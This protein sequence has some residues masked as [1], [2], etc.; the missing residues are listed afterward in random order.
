MIA[1]YVELILFVISANS[2]PL[3][4]FYTKVSVSKNALKELLN[5]TSYA[6]LVLRNV[7]HVKIMIH[8]LHANHKHLLMDNA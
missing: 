7:N 6:T 5:L 8:A 4:Q 2:L 3:I 1:K